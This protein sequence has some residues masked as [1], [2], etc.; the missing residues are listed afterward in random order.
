MQLISAHQGVGRREKTRLRRVDLPRAVDG[1]QCARRRA[2]G[3]SGLPSSP[4]DVTPGSVNSA[5][6]SYIFRS[7]R[8]G[9]AK[10][11]VERDAENVDR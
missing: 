7:E 4:Q 11:I 8:P 1:A 9:G 3:V 10:E 2:G 6:R 5:R